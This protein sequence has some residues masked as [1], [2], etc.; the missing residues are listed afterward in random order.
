MRTK[1][2]AV[3]AAAL[4]FVALSAAVEAADPMSGTW[5]LNAAK[6][7]Y[8]P[9]PAP[10][11]LTVKTESGESSYKVDATGTDAEGKPIQVQYDAKF[12][13]KD[14]PITGQPYADKVSVKRVDPSTVE[15]TMKKEGKVTMTVTT[16]LAKDGK[17]RTT[18]FKGTN[19]KG[20]AVHNVVV[21][22]KQ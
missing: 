20:Q 3:F 14:Y 10:K 22:D 18:T 6:S 13:G 15:S 16:T 7:T 1:P 8:S 12:D 17:S 4:L 5:K 2:L 11:E 21:F 19:E 9:G